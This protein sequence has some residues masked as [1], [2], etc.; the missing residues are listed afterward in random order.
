L[1]RSIRHWIRHTAIVPKGFLRFYVL[2]LLAEKPMSGSEIIHEIEAKTEGLWKPSPGSIYP[3]MSWLQDQGYVKE[4]PAEEAGTKRYML[5]DGGKAFLEEQIKARETMRKRFKLFGPL[6]FD[7]FWYD[8]HTKE[9]LELKKASQKLTE[10]VWELR[11]TLREKSS[12]KAAS[13]AKAV[14]EEAAQKIENLT[15][16]LKG[17]GE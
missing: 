11:E 16:K 12:E 15:K 7:F 4:V 14:L 2:E 9:G 3:L 13:E 17:V 1:P 6:F 10:A 5:T 8:L